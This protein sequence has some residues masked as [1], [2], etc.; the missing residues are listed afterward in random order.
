MARATSSQEQFDRSHRED[1]GGSNNA[2]TGDD[3]IDLPGGRAVESSRGAAL[4]RGRAA[5][6]NLN[7]DEANFKSERAVVEEEY[8]QRILA[9]PY[10]RFSNL[11]WPRAAYLRASVTSA[12]GI[13][14]TRTSMPRRS[15]MSSPFPRHLLPPRQRVTLINTGDFDQRQLDAWIDQLLQSRSC[16][17]RQTAATCHGRKSRRG[18]PTAS[19]TMTGPQCAAACDR[20]DLARAAG[21]ERRRASVADRHRRCS[22][23]GDSS[24]LNESLVYRRAASR[25]RRAVLST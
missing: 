3:V 8:R 17:R 12:P 19:V 15:P 1:V 11:K 23:S 16:A 9:S 22:A 18:H 7:V 14:S 25:A 6:R 24:R 2:S 21:H 10:G 13:G 4:G 20:D 5:C